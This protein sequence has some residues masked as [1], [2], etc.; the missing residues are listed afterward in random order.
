MQWF[1]ST[2]KSLLLLGHP[3]VSD[4]LSPRGLQHRKPPCHK[5]VLCSIGFYF[6]HQTHPKLSVVYSWPSLFIHSG[7][8]GNS[9]LLFPSSVL[10]TFRPGGHIFRCHIFWPFIQ[11][12]RFSQQGFWGGLP[13][14]P[15]VGHILSELSAVTHPFLVALPHMAHSFIALCKPLCCDKAMIHKGDL[16]IMWFKGI[17]MK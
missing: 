16:E 9:P 14:P 4:S 7:A 5:T 3:G 12:I 15:P 8:I 13:F 10:D 1:Y 2:Q 6:H 11:F 17:R